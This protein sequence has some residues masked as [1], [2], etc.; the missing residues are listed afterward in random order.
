MAERVAPITDGVPPKSLRTLPMAAPAAGL[1]M[2]ALIAVQFCF[3]ANYVISKIVVTNF[4]PLVWAGMRIAIAT[5]VLF[6]VCFASGRPRPKMEKSFLLPLVGFALMGTILNQASFLMGLKLTTSTNS[7]VLN[8]LIPITTLALVTIRGQEP[9][10][11]KKGL[12]FCLALAGVLSIRKF[13]DVRFTDATFIGDLLNM[14]NCVIYAFFLSY[15]KKFIEKHDALWVTAFLFLYGTVGINLI[16]IPSWL[17]YTPP[18][19]TGQLWAACAFAV[20]IGTLAAYFLNFWALKYA[21]ASQVALFIYLQPIIASAIAYLWFDQLITLR[22]AISSALI[23]MGMLTALS[24][25][26]GKAKR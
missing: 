16:A 3:G 6:S 4:P 10:N 8:T 22:V 13:E 19:M 2:A 11:W 12:G 5:V 20:G 15:S 7:A 25:S 24:G 9:L 18:V 1:V 14:F 17:T 21:K 26:Y 23:F